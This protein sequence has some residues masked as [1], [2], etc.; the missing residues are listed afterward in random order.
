MQNKEYKK[1]WRT[2]RAT[3]T[4]K[5]GKTGPRY[6]WSNRWTEW[7]GPEPPGH[8]YGM[9][10]PLNHPNTLS[11]HVDSVKQMADDP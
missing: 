2:A 10:Y 3:E 7:N 1:Y 5:K 9:A 8:S 4:Q 6:I 11:M